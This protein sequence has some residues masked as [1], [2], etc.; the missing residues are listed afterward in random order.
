MVTWTD[1]ISRFC[2]SMLAKVCGLQKISTLPTYK[3]G[4]SGQWFHVM[5][6]GCHPI[7]VMRRKVRGLGSGSLGQVAQML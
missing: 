2:L 1:S 3:Q 4:L 5:S 6:L 7:E